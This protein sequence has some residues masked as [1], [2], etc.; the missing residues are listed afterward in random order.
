MIKNKLAYSAGDS[1]NRLGSVTALYCTGSVVWGYTTPTVYTVSI[2]TVL[3]KIIY[4]RRGI[5]PY[6]A[7]YSMPSLFATLH[8]LY[9]APCSMPCSMLYSMLYTTLHTMLRVMLHAILHAMLY[10]VYLT[11]SP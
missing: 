5:A 9:H 11:P 10:T 6:A 8:A 3:L 4:G 1:V 7:C 2:L